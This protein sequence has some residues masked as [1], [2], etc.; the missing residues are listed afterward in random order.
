MFPSLTVTKPFVCLINEI[1]KGML[2]SSLC[3]SA[4]MSLTALREDAGSTPGPAQ[5]VKDPALLW[6][7]CRPAATAPIQPLDWKLPYAAGAALESKKK[8]KVHLEPLSQN[9]LCCCTCHSLSQLHVSTS[10]SPARQ[11]SLP[12][13]RDV[14]LNFLFQHD[15][16]N[17]VEVR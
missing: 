7:W 3:G 6:L 12:E 14:S 9:R 15:F 2:R 4:V 17:M 5:W 13:G 1:E 8:K 10:V 11:C 16:W